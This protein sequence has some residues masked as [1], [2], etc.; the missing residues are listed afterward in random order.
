M[1]ISAFICDEILLSRLRKA[2]VLAVYDPDRRYR[3]LC[4][5]LPDSDTAIVDASE[6]SIEAREAA[7]LALAA[8]GKPGNPKALLVYVPTKPPVTDEER[9]ADPFA[10]YAVFGAVFPD[11]D[12][13]SYESLCLKAKPDHATEIRRLFAENPSPSFALIDNVGGGLSWPTLRT[14]LHAESAREIIL[15]LLAPTPQQKDAL[16]ANDGWVP[17]AKALFEKSLGLKLM[18]KGKTHSSI[19]D[20]LWRYLLFSEFAFDLPGALP[21]AL[22]NVPKAPEEARPHVEYLC[23]ALRNAANTR[24]EYVTRAEGIEDELRIAEACAGIDDL[25][26]RDTFPFEERRVL[27]AAVSA[28]VAGD[29][30]RARD[31]LSRHGGSVWIGRGESEAQWDIVEAGLRLVAACEDADRQLAEQAGSLDALVEHYAASLVDVDRLQREFE[32][33]VGDYVPEDASLS[34]AVGLCRRRHAKLAEKVQSLFT[35]HLE[36]SGWPAHR[37]M[38][39]AD[40]FDQ[41]VEPLLRESGRRVAY[42][43]VDALRYELGVTLHRQLAETEQAELRAACAQLP[44]VT[45][46]GMASLL[47]GSAADLR[48]LRDEDGFCVALQG[49]KLASVAQRMDVLRARLGDRFAEAQLATWLRAK[50]KV[51]TS[52]ELLVLRTVDIDGH[53]ENTPSGAFSTLDLIHQALKS[54]RVAVHKLKQAGF[55]DVVI[56][57]DHGFVLNAHAEAG[58]VCTKPPGAWVVAHDRALLGEGE[59]NGANFVLLAERAGVRGDFQ[60]LAGP[61]SMSAYRKGLLYYHGGASLQEAIV[62]VITV[63]LKRVEQPELAVAKVT[64]SYKAGATSK[65]TTRL[66]VVD[67]AVEGANMFSLGETFEIMLEAH[68]KKGEV[69]GEAKRGGHVDVATGTVTVKPGGRVQVTIKMAMEFEGKFVLKALNPVTLALYAS[70]DLETAYAV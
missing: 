23:D 69:V 22:S 49:D 34:D 52:V 29:L 39:N 31:I 50:N 53:L 8:L 14:C 54:I 9:Q 64:L 68:N 38:S 51:P 28:L 40:V 41:I 36:S 24:A 32:Q 2:S 10:V 18:T 61:R 57:T 17:E 44:T 15:A 63:R 55:A 1:S 16:K 60:K 47:P 46:V 4:H 11:G 65:I 42:I 62:P 13:D 35:K 43:L 21:L 26:V 6:S 25:G 67:L 27:T 7:M 56:A 45:S 37:L 66:P 3:D 5:A 12:G 70:L 33:A 19:A 58:E 48:L 20:E 30:D 59:A